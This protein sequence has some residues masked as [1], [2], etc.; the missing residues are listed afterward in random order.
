MA[1]FTN[2]QPMHQLTLCTLLLPPPGY[3]C[4]CSS[5]VW[6]TDPWCCFQLCVFL[7]HRSSHWCVPRAGGRNGR[8]GVLDRTAVWINYT[9]NAQDRMKS[10]FYHFHTNTLLTHLRF[11]QSVVFFVVLMTMDWEKQ[12]KTV[13]NPSL[14]HHKRIM[15]VEWSP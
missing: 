6:S 13:R 9:G 14:I 1:L 10:T 3:T 15:Y 7:H 2:P 4:W 8:H 5:W 11:Q 12:S